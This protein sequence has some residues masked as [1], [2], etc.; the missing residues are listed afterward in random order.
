MTFGDNIIETSSF[1][2]L[3]LY[4]STVYICRFGQ[5]ISLCGFETRGDK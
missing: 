2:L 4:V 5:E 3:Q 1:G